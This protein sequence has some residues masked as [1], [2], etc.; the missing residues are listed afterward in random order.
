MPHRLGFLLDHPNSPQGLA[1]FS[2]WVG[3]PSTSHPS[4][5]RVLPQALRVS[6]ADSWF[7]GG[8]QYPNPSCIRNF[9]PRLGPSNQIGTVSPVG[10]V[11]LVTSTCCT[12]RVAS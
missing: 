4:G 9:R 7:C 10:A 1:N 11:G 2:K 3:T 6:G 5:H 12:F 8:R